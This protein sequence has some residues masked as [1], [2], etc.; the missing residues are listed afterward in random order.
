MA[1]ALLPGS[2]GM[3]R[4]SLRWQGFQMEVDHIVFGPEKQAFLL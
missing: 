1:D 4:L 3:Y 2:M